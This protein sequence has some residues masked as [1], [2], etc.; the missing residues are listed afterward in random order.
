MGN[1]P[2]KTTILATILALTAIPAGA[3]TITT[4]SIMDRNVAHT[5]TLTRTGKPGTGKSA[6]NGGLNP[7]QMIGPDG[8]APY[9]GRYNAYKPAAGEWI[10]S[11][12]TDKSRLSIMFEAPTD[13]F[14]FAITDFA[15]WLRPGDDPYTIKYRDAVYRVS[16][17]LLNSNSLFLTVIFDKAVTRANIHF[18]NQHNDAFGFAAAPVAPVPLPAGIWLIGAALVAIW[19]IS[20][21][22]RMT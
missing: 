6:I 14:S 16:D 19:G 7:V 5:A 20:R 4:G 9:L 1:N 17:Q 13:R 2:L 11:N 3:A 10:F 12:D 18:R 21:R 8:T 22:R 15:D